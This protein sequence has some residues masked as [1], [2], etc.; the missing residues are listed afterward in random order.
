[1]FR[2]P[3]EVE[4]SIEIDVKREKVLKKIKN[5][6]VPS[7]FKEVINYLTIIVFIL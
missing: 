7:R 1:M 4:R 2:K 3:N 5:T 6:I